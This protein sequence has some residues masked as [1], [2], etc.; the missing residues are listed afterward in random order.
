MARKRWRRRLLVALAA[1][2]AIGIA[3]WSI[4]ATRA[5]LKALGLV[6]EIAGLP[7]PRPWAAPVDAEEKEIAPG[8]VGDL[9]GP[10]DA[11]PILFVPGATKRGRGDERVVEAARALARAGRRVFVPE[12]DLY[13]KVFRR[14]DVDR[15]VD[16]LDVL[17]ETRPVGVVGFSYGGSFAIIAAANPTVSEDVAFVATFGS[18]YDLGN[19]VQGITT[20]ST[21]LDGETV[22]FATVPEAREIL[23]DTAIELLAGSRAKQLDAALRTRDPSSLPRGPRAVYDLLANEDPEHTAGLLAGLP[24]GIQEK[25]RFFSPATYSENLAAPLFVMQAREDPATPWTEAVLLERAV[26]GSRLVVLDGFS[27]VDAPGIKGW[28]E[29]APGAWSFVSWILRAQE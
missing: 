5:R 15:L 29:D 20:G 14:S 22:E 4:P 27:H 2:V 1:V 19:V 9:Y 11:A 25:L 8:V 6:A 17:S 24:R 23:V 7:I 21:T 12:L 18:Y 13:E 26:P 10:P 3:L 16:A 28:L